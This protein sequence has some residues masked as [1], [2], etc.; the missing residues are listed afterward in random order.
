MK[1]L[2][3]TS[4][5]SNYT[6]IGDVRHMY[7]GCGWLQSAEKAICNSSDVDLAVCF[8][9]NGQPP[10]IKQNKVT[11]YPI[12]NYPQSKMTRLKY[13][14]S[15]IIGKGIDYDE[16]KWNYYKRNLQIVI[17]DFQPDII[18]IWGS[19]N[20]LGL[21]GDIAKCPVVLHIQ[22]I[23]NPYM[24]AFLPPAFSWSDFR[25]I[26]V[27]PMF[28]LKSC[29]MKSIWEVNTHRERHIINSVRFYL[30][31]TEWD[32]RATFILNPNMVYFKVDE[33][34]RDEFYANSQRIIP[35]KLVIV[36]TIS[37]PPYKGY[38][39]VLKTAKLLKENLHLEFEWQCFGDIVPDLIEQKVKIKH[40]DVNVKLM[41]VATA[42]QIREAELHATLYFHSSYI[43]N[44]PNSLC[45]AQM[46]GLP[47]VATNVGG[48]PSLV[49]DGLTGFLIPANDPYQGAFCVNSLYKDRQLNVNM[50]KNG[51]ERAIIRHDPNKVI[52]QIINMYN[53]VLEEI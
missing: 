29:I 4:T 39:L 33:V 47:I 15:M 23:L 19:E 21:V 7:N 17:D 13:Y 11:Y 44:S 32:K 9:L 51:K 12:S 40:N 41:G 35:N 5:P 52:K 37:S 42:N 31:R 48:I 49:E 22:G 10:K 25:R 53:H 18:H 50:G 45:E 6:P 20:P 8:L 24:N 1:I 16:L 43:D 3:L 27:H 2:W 34:L 28:F 30:G 46:L 36:T 26:S 38:D 14:W